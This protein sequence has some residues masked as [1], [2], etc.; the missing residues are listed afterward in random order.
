[1][2]HISGKVVVCGSPYTALCMVPSLKLL[3]SVPREAIYCETRI[4]LPT[5]LCTDPL[6]LKEVD[7]AMLGESDHCKY[8]KILLTCTEKYLFSLFS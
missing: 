3:S 1:M 8:H 2:S 4:A 5:D 7:S 6:L